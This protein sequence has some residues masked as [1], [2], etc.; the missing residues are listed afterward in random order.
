[1]TKEQLVTRAREIY[2]KNGKGKNLSNTDMDAAYNAISQAIL[3]ALAANETVS[4]SCNVGSF[5]VED[6]PERQ[7]RNPRTGE[8]ITIAAKKAVKFRP[9]KALKDTLNGRS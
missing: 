6:K 4:F 1:M 3:E 5:R 7:G 9:G 8:A 2:M